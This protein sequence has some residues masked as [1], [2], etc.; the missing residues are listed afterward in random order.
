M[1]YVLN[2]R[3]IR[4]LCISAIEA[5]YNVKIDYGKTKMTWI[6]P[7]NAKDRA[8]Y[9]CFKIE[10]PVLEIANRPEEEEERRIDPDL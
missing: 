3:E 2:N 4:E 5:K 10:L 7:D 1:T 9:G 8:L 6:G